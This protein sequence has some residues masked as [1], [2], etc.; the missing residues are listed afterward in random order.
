MKWYFL[1]IIVAVSIGIGIVV[2]KYVL[3]PKATTT[4]DPE[5]VGG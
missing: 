1:V 4:P 3:S 5:K 2:D